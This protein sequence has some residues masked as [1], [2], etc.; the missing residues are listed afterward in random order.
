MHCELLGEEVSGEPGW[1]DRNFAGRPRY[2]TV[3]SF[4]MVDYPIEYGSHYITYGEWQRCEE[5]GY[6][7]YTAI[8]RPPVF[9][10]NVQ[11]VWIMAYM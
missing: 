5:L 1:Q 4:G 3:R 7:T 2:R 9:L 6:V 10:D 11:S 8:A